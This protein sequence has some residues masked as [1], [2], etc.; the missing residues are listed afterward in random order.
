MCSMRKKASMVMTKYDW[1][2]V[3][4]PTTTE[5]PPSSSLRAYCG[6]RWGQNAQDLVFG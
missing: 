2:I 6:H 4:R 1:A 5:M 3:P